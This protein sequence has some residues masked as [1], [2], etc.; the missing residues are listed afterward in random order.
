M[1]MLL[2]PSKAVLAGRTDVGELD[3]GPVQDGAHVGDV[4]AA[5]IGLPSN[6]PDSEQQ[7]DGETSENGASAPIDASE[8]PADTALGPDAAG[9]GTQPADA[10]DASPQ[11]ADAPAQDGTDAAAGSAVS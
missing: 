6:E 11:A 3:S 8:Q 10:A 7:G 5:A 2:T 1:T 4:A 9:N